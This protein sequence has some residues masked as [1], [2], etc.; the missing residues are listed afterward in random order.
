MNR[1]S[2]RQIGVVSLLVSG[3]SMVAFLTPALS[4]EAADKTI[5]PATSEGI[6]NAIDE[7]ATELKTTIDSGKLENVHHEAFAIRDLVAALPSHSATL[8]ADKLAKVKTS[9]KFVATLA[10]RLDA[11]GDAKDVAGTKDNFTKLKGI[12][13]SIRANYSLSP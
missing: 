6:W 11:T 5:I 1:L 7:K 13:T 3:M 8:A 10:E 4:E 9:V 12:L 2:L